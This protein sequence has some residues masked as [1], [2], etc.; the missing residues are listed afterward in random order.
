MRCENIKIH[1]ELPININKPDG[2][3]VIYSEEAVK[4]ACEKASNQPI[5]TYNDK[6]ES[7]VVGMANSIKYE[8]GKI[9]VD[10]FTY[11]GGTSETVIINDNKVVSSMEILG[12][13]LCE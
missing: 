12:F 11:A 2:N 13:G 1:M 3:G 4:S 5:I 9:L 7:V 8:D 10:G 6:G